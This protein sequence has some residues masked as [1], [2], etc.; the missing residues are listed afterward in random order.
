MKQVSVVIPSFNRGRLLPQ[1]LPT[2]FQAEVGEVILVD[3]ASTDNTPQVV[4]E[5]QKQYPSLR[6]VRLPENRRQMYAKNQGIQLATYPYIYFGDDDSFLTDGSIETLLAVMQEKTADIVGAKALYMDNQEDLQALPVFLK[7]YEKQ[8]QNAKEVVDLSQLRF[9]FTLSSEQ[10][11][12]VPVTH[13]CFLI[14]TEWA[15]AILFD[16][17][18]R[19]NAYREETDFLIRACL[20]GAVAYYQPAAIQI[21]LPREMATGGAHSQSKWKWH[22]ACIINNWYFLNKNY[23][24]MQEQFNLP[25]SKWMLQLRFVCRGVKKTV[26]RFGGGRR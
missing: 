7:K 13:A 10:A 26:E 14:R 16:E 22:V 25:Y 18:Y 19:W 2:Y 11:L 12:R 4:A 6:Y 8:A 1:I 17:A 24:A 21:N 23:A 5:L 15:R 3:D 9:N 20:A